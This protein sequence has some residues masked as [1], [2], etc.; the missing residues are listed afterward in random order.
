MHVLPRVREIEERF[1]DSLTGIG[2]H[3]GKYSTERLTDRIADACDRLGVAHAVVNDRQ[4]RIW[5]EYAVSAWPTVVV[6]DP[7]GYIALIAPGEFDVAA[8][9]A[10]LDANRASAPNRAVRSFAAPT[11]SP[12]RR[13]TTRGLCASHHGR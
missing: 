13:S 10:E 1:A 9:I 6:V 5:K 7:E 2:V 4:F 8:M 12:S 11:R 3:A